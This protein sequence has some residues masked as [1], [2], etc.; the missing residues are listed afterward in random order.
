MVKGSAEGSSLLNLFQV[1]PG[2]RVELFEEVFADER[3]DACIMSI[4]VTPKGFEV[5][6]RR[7]CRLVALCGVG[8]LDANNVGLSCKSE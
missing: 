7:P 5:F 6:W 8:F 4:A 1:F 2:Y 3:G